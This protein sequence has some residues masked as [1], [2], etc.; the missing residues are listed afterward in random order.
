[1]IV[2][3]AYVDEESDRQFER[4]GFLQNKLFGTVTEVRQSRLHKKSM[5]TTVQK[6]L[7]AGLV[8]TI[9]VVGSLVLVQ[10][11]DIVHPSQ[12]TGMPREIQKPMQHS[13]EPENIPQQTDTG[14]AQQTAPA[15]PASGATGQETAA[16]TTKTVQAQSTFLQFS[17]QG[18]GYPYQGTFT[19][20]TADVELADSVF[21][22]ATVRIQANSVDAG[23]F[24]VNSQLKG[25]DF[26]NVDDYPE[27]LL[28]IQDSK[29]ESTNVVA[30]VTIRG[31]TRMFEFPATITIS[32]FTADF[33]V[34]VSQ[35]GITH[36]NVDKNVHMRVSSEWTTPE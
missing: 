36:P 16:Q 4:Q 12:E 9:I 7:L 1:M 25:K 34:D 10:R 24:I 33:T 32:S 15:S 19:D 6:I 13:N 20:M 28:S 30:Q 35:Y 5:K 8:A 23:N 3:D 2:L 22:K 21:H 17:G 14:A 27:I 11:N 18:F 31:V 29:E 26:L